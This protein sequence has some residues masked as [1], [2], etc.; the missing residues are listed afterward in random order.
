LVGSPLFRSKFT[1]HTI[2]V[3]TGDMIYLFTDGLVDQLEEHLRRK[4][5]RSL[6]REMFTDV[7]SLPMQEQHDEILLR[8]MQW[9]GTDTQTDDITVFGIRV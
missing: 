4:F 5:S 7:A 1:N 3:S 2:D 8:I 9:K 6:A